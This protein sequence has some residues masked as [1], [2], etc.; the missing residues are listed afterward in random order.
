MKKQASEQ[1]A[2]DFRQALE[3]FV[4]AGREMLL[5]GET[6]LEVGVKMADKFLEEKPPAHAPRPPTARAWS[7][8]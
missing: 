4:A 6:L 8:R 7:I 5:A 3:H 2:V 1:L